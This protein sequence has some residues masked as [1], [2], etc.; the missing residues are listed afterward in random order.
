MAKL[1]QH[2]VKKDHKVV[3]HKEWIAARKA[4]LV[5]EKQFTRLRDELSR[6]RRQLPWEKVEKEYVFDGPNGKETLAELFD[7]KSQLIIYHF[8]FDPTWKEGCFACSFWADNFNGLGVHL[9]HRDATMLAISRA[10]LP[11][12][13]AFQKRMKWSFKWVSSYHADFNFDYGVSFLPKDWK[14]GPVSYNYV[15]EKISSGERPG[16]SVFYKNAGGEIFH[17]YSCFARGLDMMNN[18]YQYLDLTPKGRDEDKLDF[19]MAWLRYHD[20]YKD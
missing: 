15:S 10:S 9:K 14:N 12:L 18:V 7:G 3:S 11:K 6:Q 13:Q 2:T 4:F 1:K 5:K 16:I 19:T 17:T 20:R 8:M